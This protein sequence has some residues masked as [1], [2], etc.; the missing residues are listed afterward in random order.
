MESEEACVRADVAARLSP[1]VVAQRLE[2]EYGIREEVGLACAR[3]VLRERQEAQVAAAHE[4]LV[5][6]FK[7]CFEV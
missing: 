5:D 2:S 1:E 7:R 3:Q 4:A 6:C